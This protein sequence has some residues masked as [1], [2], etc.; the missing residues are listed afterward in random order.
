VPASIIVIAPGTM[1]KGGV[2]LDGII[3]LSPNQL[4]APPPSSNISISYFFNKLFAKAR[5]KLVAPTL[6]VAP[7]TAITL[8][9]A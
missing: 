5:E 4:D 1:P 7:I 9:C 8:D 3:L 2:F 6:F